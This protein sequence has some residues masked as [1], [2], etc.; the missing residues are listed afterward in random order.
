MYSLILNTNAEFLK[1]RRTNAIWLTLA[2]ALFIPSVN[3]LKLVSR[4]DVFVPQTK[5]DPWAYMLNDNWAPGASLFLP[6]YVILVI[7]LVAQIEFTNNTWKQVYASPR[8]YADIYFS[9]LFVMLFLILLWIVLLSFF[10]IASGYIVEMAN[11]DYV[12]TG[13]PVPWRQLSTIAIK[14]FAS[15][16]GIVAI[17]YWL[18][19]S[20]KSFVT[21][22]GIG[23]A[24]LTGGLMIRQWE[25]ISYYPYMHPLLV[26]FPN[27]GLEEGTMHK[28]ILNSIAESVIV[29][30]LGF[31]HVC[32]RKEKG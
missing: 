2:G 8:S 5:A 10:M 26:Y 6:M 7:S 32:I 14:M 11:S 12:F 31:Y 21:P 16:L 17:Q 20:F 15:T 4:P 24:L 25:Y 30:G 23:M 18:S 3:F 13:R 9:K 28:T 27:P 19:L 29:L 1:I 22:I